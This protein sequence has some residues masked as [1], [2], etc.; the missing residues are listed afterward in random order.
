M[1]D[2][3]ADSL[4]Q[5]VQGEV[6]DDEKTLSRYATDMSMYRIE[7]L[8]VVLPQSADDVVATVRFAAQERIPVTARGGG[9]STA[10][11]ALGRGIMLGFE[12]RGPMSRILDFSDVDGEPRVRVEPALVHDDLQGF[13]RARG[14]YLPS[15]PSSGAIS[16]LGGN[17]ATKASGPHALRHGSIDRYLR[18]LQFVTAQGEI[19]DTSDEVTIPTRIREGILAL[20]KDVLA[21]LT[22]VKRL[23]SRKDMKLASGYNLFTFLRHQQLGEIVAQLLVGS[24]G[25]LGV[26][27]QVTLRAEPYVECHSAMLLYFRDLHQAGDAVQHIRALDVAAIEIMDH[28]TITIVRERY[29]DVQVPDGEV[30]MLLVEFEGAERNDQMA[31]VQ[32][33]LRDKNYDLAGEPHTARD[34]TEQERLWKVRKSLFPVLRNYQANMKAL[35]LVNDVGVDPSHLADLIIDLQDIFEHHGLLAAIY[36][37]AGSGNLHLRPLFDVRDPHLPALLVRLADEVYEA[38]FRYDGTITA[39]HGMGRLRVSYLASEWSEEIVG[40]MRRVKTIF[41]PDDLLNPDVMFGNRP[42][43]DDIDLAQHPL[44]P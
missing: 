24:V 32:D 20:R 26:I 25:T 23:E 14:L 37:H 4:R 11:S 36:G 7:P 30:H 40:Y 17:V 19:V 34:Q 28:R 35:S 15:D 6:M 31:H 27:T 9:S 44:H 1:S 18:H 42:L 43:T 16:V 2:T 41:D 21:D 13:L 3:L 8:A 39:E 10:G 38:M 29:P 5:R 33:L 22:T 12:R